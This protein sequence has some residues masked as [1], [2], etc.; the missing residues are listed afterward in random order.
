M[1]RK[2]LITSVAALSLAACTQREVTGGALGAGAGAVVG[3]A[4][5]GDVE[6]ALVGGAVGAVAGTLVAG[7]TEPRPG[8]CRYHDGRGGTYV[9]ECPR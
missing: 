6:G 2:F 4:V 8:Y 1:I 7:A 5:T 3:A 9:A